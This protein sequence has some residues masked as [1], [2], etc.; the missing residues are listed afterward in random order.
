MRLPSHPIWAQSFAVS[1]RSQ[2]RSPLV[3]RDTHPCRAHSRH[4]R[5]SARG[6]DLLVLPGLALQPESADMCQHWFVFHLYGKAPAVLEHLPTP[7]QIF[8]GRT[9]GNLTSI[10]LI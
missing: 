3:S 10:F 7:H 4:D 6:N 9:G 2:T 1:D 5:V 8:I